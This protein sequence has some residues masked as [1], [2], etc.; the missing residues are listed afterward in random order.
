MGAFLVPANSC[1]NVNTELLGINTVLAYCLTLNNY[2]IM[3]Y[4]G[5]TVVTRTTQTI[6]IRTAHILH[7]IQ[8]LERKKIDLTLQWIPNLVNTTGDEKVDEIAKGATMFSP[9]EEM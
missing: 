7:I 8:N 4:V 1:S 5:C 2:K 3:Y 9:I 6:S